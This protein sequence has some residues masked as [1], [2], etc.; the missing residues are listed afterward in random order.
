MTVHAQTRKKELVDGLFTLGLSIS[1]SRVLEISSDL[2]GKACCQFEKDGVVC[3]MKLRFGLF[4]TAAV[5]NLDHNPSSTTA[6]DS[7]HGTAVSIFQHPTDS[8]CGEERTCL[9]LT[10]GQPHKGLSVPELPKFYS[11]VP[12]FALKLP[13]D[14][15]PDQNVHPVGDTS[16]HA[17][18]METENEWL[19][20]METAVKQMSTPKHTS[21]GAFHASKEQA[22][23]DR[24]PGITS[25]LPL[26][27]EQSKSLAMMKHAM[28]IVTKAVKF[29][30]PAQNP[31][32]ACDQPLFALAKQIQ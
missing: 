15:P 27:H 24:T 31:V 4:T 3:P 8:S 21:W 28:D 18:A 23:K 7:F 9:D 13:V 11:E 22:E 29:L 30:N 1:Y 6:K 26:F 2:A 5:D 16:Q 25:L 20:T 14:P 10:D 17:R 32:I 19:E 12:P